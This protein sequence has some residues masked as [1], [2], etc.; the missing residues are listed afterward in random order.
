MIRHHTAPNAHTHPF[1]EGTGPGLTFTAPGPEDLR[2]TNPAGNYIELRLTATDSQGLSKT[3]S[4][5]L[6]P[7]VTYLRFATRPAEF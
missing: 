3:V 5:R 2:S 4:Q 1:K 7:K 6:D